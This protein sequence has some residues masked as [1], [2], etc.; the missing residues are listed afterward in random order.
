MIGVHKIIAVDS[1][2]IMLR[3]GLVNGVKDFFARIVVFRQLKAIMPVVF[4]CDLLLEYKRTVCIYQHDNGIRACFRR[5][6]AMV[7]DLL[8]H[9]YRCNLRGR[10]AVI[11]RLPAGAPSSVMAVSARS[12]PFSSVTVTVMV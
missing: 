5:V 4:R 8:P 11:A 6:G 7:A 10:A 2:V 9:D 1:L 3:L 12:A